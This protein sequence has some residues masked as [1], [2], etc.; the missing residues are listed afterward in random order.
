MPGYAG[1]DSNS[2][3]QRGQAV[4][5]SGAYVCITEDKLN[6]LRTA[7]SEKENQAKDWALAHGCWVNFMEEPITVKS[8]DGM[9]ENVNFYMYRPD[10]ERNDL[11][12][13]QMMVKQ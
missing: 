2:V 11:W 6:E 5:K 12:A 10:G 7:L 4:L 3:L 9:N 1:K 13:M 8:A